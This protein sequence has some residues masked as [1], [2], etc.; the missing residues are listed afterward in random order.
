MHLAE[1]RA[2]LAQTENE[3][4][5]KKAD[6][7]LK[8]YQIPCSVLKQI[9]EDLMKGVVGSEEEKNEIIQI[10]DNDSQLITRTLEGKKDD[11]GR[12]RILQSQEIEGFLFIFKNRELNKISRNI[13]QAFAV[14]TTHSSNEIKQLIF[15]KKPF[16]GLLRLLDHTDRFVA[17]DGIVSILNILN[18]GTKT[19][20]DN[21]HHPHYETI[22]ACGGIQMII[23]LFRKNGSKYSKDRAAIC[24]GQLFRAREINDKQMRVEIIR[25]LKT[26]VNDSD[27]W[28]KKSAKRRLG[29][30]AQN[31]INKTEI[32]SGGFVIPD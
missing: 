7:L 1:E 32:Q 16:P 12:R 15:D 9:G 8:R 3:Q 23:R 24:I 4:Q 5:R 20:P 13:S 21:S 17:D 29:G 30:L 6:E 14:I 25:H 27:E 18:G 28:T 31:E 19:T 11:E 22:N 26:L 2:I 10:Q